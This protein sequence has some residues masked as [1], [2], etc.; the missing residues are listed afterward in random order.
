MN[1]ISPVGLVSQAITEGQDTQAR[2]PKNSTRNTKNA[3]F[4]PIRPYE[5][6]CTQRA[7]L[8]QALTFRF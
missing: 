3:T 5:K 1:L 7:K 8:P 4:P 6:N 2:T